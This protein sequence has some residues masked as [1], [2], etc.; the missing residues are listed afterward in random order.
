MPGEPLS[1]RS[2]LDH[3]Q[4]AWQTRHEAASKH[5]CS[6][7]PQRAERCSYVL[8]RAWMTFLWPISLGL[9]SEDCAGF[10]R[11][12]GGGQDREGPLGVEGKLL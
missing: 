11:L 6:T 9:V 8:S 12:L 10:G 3:R 5:Y 1:A 4:P 7:G 2:D